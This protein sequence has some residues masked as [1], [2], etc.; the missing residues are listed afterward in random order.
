MTTVL[1]RVVEVNGHEV[2]SKA[3]EV[4]H[5]YEI[6]GRFMIVREVGI[7]PSQHLVCVLYVYFYQVLYAVDWGAG[8]LRACK[9]SLSTKGLM[10]AVV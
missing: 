1:R 6:K 3:I 10:L 7:V 8:S 4:L 9:K 5:R 2:A